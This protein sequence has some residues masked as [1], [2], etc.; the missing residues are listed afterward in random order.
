[1][2]FYRIKQ[3]YWVIESLY[4]KDDFV[5]LNKYLNES[6]LNLFMKIDKSER[7][8]SIRVCKSVI[9][10]IN[11][12]NIVEIDENKICKCAL[13]HDIGKAKAKLNIF[14]KSIIIII[15]TITCGKF[16]KYNKSK[17]IVNYYNHAQ[18]GAELLEEIKGISFDVIECVRYHHNKDMIEK[19]IYLEI[20][21]LCDNCN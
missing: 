10:Y 19:N 17:K 16:L 1:M 12:K 4:I 2:I 21:S 14:H 11:N 7:Y 6:E 5:I 9:K 13:L 18:I 3:F 8:H 15:N 20:L